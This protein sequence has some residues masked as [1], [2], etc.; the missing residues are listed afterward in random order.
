MLLLMTCCNNHYT[1]SNT[2]NNFP[3]LFEEYGLYKNIN[4][5][6]FRRFNSWWK[7]VI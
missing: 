4:K 6:E 1:V 2:A 3:S 7:T 5:Q